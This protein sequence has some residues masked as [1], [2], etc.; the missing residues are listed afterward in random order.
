MG[1]SD[2]AELPGRLRRVP[3]DDAHILGRPW[4][5][6]PGCDIARASYCVDCH[7]GVTNS[8]LINLLDWTWGYAIEDDQ[9]VLIGHDWDQI[10]IPELSRRTEAEIA[11]YLQMAADMNAARAARLSGKG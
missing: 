2:I 11:E 10:R 8:A 1:L 4:R 9:L 6:V 7:L 5:R 3:Y